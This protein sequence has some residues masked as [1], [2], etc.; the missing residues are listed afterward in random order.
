M[1][2]RIR[3][4][5]EK[6]DKLTEAIVT[7][8]AVMEKLEYFNHRLDKADEYRKELNERITENNEKIHQLSLITV[9]QTNFINK[10]FWA[11]VTLFGTVAAGVVA[12]IV[13]VVFTK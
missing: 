4:L 5:E 6:T 13:T 10:A 7:L 11:G 2:D 1:E 9:P 8:A 12:S 3:R